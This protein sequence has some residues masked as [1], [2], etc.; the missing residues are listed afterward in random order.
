MKKVLLYF[1][2]KYQGDYKKI[3][4]AIEAKEQID[5]NELQEVE[6][7][8]RCKYITLLDNNYPDAFKHTGTPPFVLF[9]YGDISLLN[10]PNKIAMIGCRKNSMYG[11]IMSKK[12]VKDFK[13]DNAICVSGLAEGIDSISHLCALENNIKTIAV[14]GSGIDYCYPS[15]NIDIYNA[16]KEKGLLISEY[17]NNTKPLPHYFL[18]RNRII[19]AIS[20]YVCVVEANYKSG[21]MNTVAYALEYGK[22][23]C[24]VPSLATNNS[25][26]NKLI[27]EGARLIE[28]YKDIMDE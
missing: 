2:L 7:K 13:K 5:K 18:I 4:S 9:Y 25:G 11:E 28:N 1:A 19:A 6:N 12:I 14:L 26:C 24:C 8:I 21:T 20:D 27:K 17:P 22:D 16:I 15:I 23:V 10:K 3:L